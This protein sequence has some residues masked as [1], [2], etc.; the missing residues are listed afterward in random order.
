MTLNIDTIREDFSVMDDWEDRYRYLID[1][2]REL[3]PF[4]E[5]ARDDAHK[6]NGCASQ[7][8]VVADVAPGA[9]P[10]IAF[11]GD[12][13]AHIVRGLVAIMIA[14]LSGRTAS[15]VAATDVEA[16]FRELGLDTHLSQQRANGLRSMVRRMKSE[17]ETART[18]A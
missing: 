8:W 17:A 4:P 16:V 1:L 6:V 13:D 2:G 9:D 14:L 3:E 12:P 10:V 7:V 5:A 11:R 15:A 18:P